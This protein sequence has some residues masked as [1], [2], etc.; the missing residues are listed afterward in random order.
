MRSTDQNLIGL[1]N[2]MG[3]LQEIEFSGRRSVPF[4][5]IYPR[6]QAKSLAISLHVRD[7]KLIGAF[8]IRRKH[9]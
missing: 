4:A 6:I 3:L 2:F 5:V 9:F 1:F 8:K 7:K